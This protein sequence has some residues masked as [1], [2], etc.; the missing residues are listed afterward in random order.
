MRG[1]VALLCA[2]GTAHALGETCSTLWSKLAHL[3]CRPQDQPLRD[4]LDTLTLADGGVVTLRCTEGHE[5]CYRTDHAIELSQQP[6]SLALTPEP[7]SS[8]A[9]SARTAPAAAAA[10][11]AAYTYHT[12]SPRG[13][14][15]GRWHHCRHGLW[16]GSR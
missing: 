11:A 16:G 15:R 1:L 10:A 4:H 2:V 8:V 13:Y 9:H 5:L 14:P 7:F 12:Y 3:G 6:P